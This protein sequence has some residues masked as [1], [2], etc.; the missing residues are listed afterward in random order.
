MHR[1][2]IAFAREGDPGWPAY[3][4]TRRATMRFDVD[5]DVVDDPESTQRRAWDLAT[6]RRS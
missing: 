5:S 3:D 6:L 4:T 2:W 1:A